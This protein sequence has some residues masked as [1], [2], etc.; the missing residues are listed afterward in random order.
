MQLQIAEISCSYGAAPVLQDVT[1]HIKDHAMLGIVGPNGSGKSSL[2]RT[3]SRVLPPSKGK[4]LLES[5]DLYQMPARQAAKNIAVV[6]QEQQFD[7]PFTV[8]DIVMMGRIPHLK[9]FQKESIKDHKAVQ[10]AMQA[11]DLLHLADRPVTKL[12]GGEKQRVLIARA[13]AQEPAVLLLDEPTSYLDLNYQL[14]IMEL[15]Q[16]L[17]HE[18]TITIVMVL[19]DINLACQYCDDLLVLKDGKIQAAG[20][21]GQLI[22][23][24]FIRQIYGCEVQ[25]EM[26]YPGGRPL[27]LLQ[28]SK[29]ASACSTGRLVHVV[30]GGGIS[31]ELFHLLCDHGYTISTGVI[32]IGDSDWQEAKRLGIEVIEAE[33]F[34]P[35]T[36]EQSKL[37]II[38]MEESD[39][40]ILDAIPFG[41][42][43]LP[44][45]ESVLAQ[46][47]QGK[48]VIVVG[49][50]NIGERDYTG[51]IAEA[52]YNQLI[53]CAMYMVDSVNEAIS[54][55]EG[56]QGHDFKR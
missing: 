3:I 27:V 42:G 50:L 24:A 52:L 6:G 38:Y 31:S 55:M 41:P 26:Q 12:S 22:N 44:N 5:A 54:L 46:A 28:K 49:G 1:F 39:F 43:N 30:G 36:A 16:R 45:L 2:L 48:K 20:P 47:R 29:S 18:Q 19:H 9:R 53:S 11:A 21:P 15:L 40:I 35:V 8:N 32:N 23:A 25:V 14:E 7:Y 17:H 33:P 4:V 34:C 56:D 13:L 10:H 37:N 51:G